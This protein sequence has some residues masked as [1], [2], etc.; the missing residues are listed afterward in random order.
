M[1]NGKAE[2]TRLYISFYNP[3]QL[4]GNLFAY[5][6]IVE[7][8]FTYPFYEQQAITPLFYPDYRAF[9]LRLPRTF[10]KGK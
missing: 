8:I 4:A 7:T 10:G 6:W 3:L 2:F 1:K 9:I 5:V